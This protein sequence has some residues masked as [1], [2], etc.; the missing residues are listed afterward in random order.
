MAEI[1]MSMIDKEFIPRKLARDENRVAGCLANCNHIECTT[2]VWMHVGT[3]CIED[4]L[5]LNC[6]ILNTE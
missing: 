6:N 5:P 1:K 2:A 3:P 4:L